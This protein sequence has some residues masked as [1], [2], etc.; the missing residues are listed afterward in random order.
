MGSGRSTTQT[1]TATVPQFLED[2]YTQSVFP[3][4]TQI[5]ETPFQ[6]YGG[7]FVA[8]VSEMSMAAQPYYEQIGAIS[9]MT[10]ADYQAMTE[11]NLSSYTA[12]VMD[13]A[14]AR[15]ARE[16]EIART[17][18]Q[19]DI[20][21]AGAFGN[22][23]RGVYEAEREAAYQ[24]AQDE[25]IANLMRQGYNE[26]QA[27]TMAQLQMGQGAAGQA[28]AG[29]QQLGALQQT[30]DQAALEAAYNEFLREQQY[31]LTQLGAMVGAGGLGAG[32]IGQTATTSERPGF[33]GTLAALGSLGQGFAAFR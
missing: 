15:M 7:E 13:P 18:E 17:Q 27:A 14:L 16:R 9:G 5:G 2:Y 6:A 28:A 24:V 1:T 10:P 31:P 21:R 32:M 8:P 19:A 4:A 12:N 3:A 11:A 25:L 29:M 30:T 26:A 22:V 33:S 23:R 20:A